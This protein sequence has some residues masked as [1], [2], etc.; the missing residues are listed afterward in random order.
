VTQATLDIPRAAKLSPDESV[1]FTAVVMALA[2]LLVERDVFTREQLEIRAQEMISN[3]D[4]LSAADFV[5]AVAQRIFE[6]KF[7]AQL[8]KPRPDMTGFCPVVPT[9]RRF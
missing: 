1:C 2:D 4:M 6:K 3:P 8:E 5:K 9:E 7:G